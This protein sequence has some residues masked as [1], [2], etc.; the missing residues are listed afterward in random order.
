MGSLVRQSIVAIVLLF[1]FGVIFFVTKPGTL[2]IP[3]PQQNNQNSNSGVV[4]SQRSMQ[5]QT[6]PVPPSNYSAPSPTDCRSTPTKPP[7]RLGTMGDRI[8]GDTTSYLVSYAF[9]HA[10]GRENTVFRGEGAVQEARKL[11]RSTP[12]GEALIDVGA[13]VGYVSMYGAALGRPVIAVEPI[14]YLISKLCEGWRAN[15]ES[16]QV[17]VYHAAAGATDNSSVI[18]TRP[19]DAVGNFGESSLSRGAVFQKDIVTEKI[20]MLRLDSVVPSD[21][22]VGVVK[23]DVQGHEANVVAGMAAILSRDRGFPRHV[24]YETN[25]QIEKASGVRPGE[26]RRLLEGHGYRCR[27][28]CGSDVHCQKN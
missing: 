18:I 15:G 8:P 9:Y 3:A 4:K 16:S 7:M 28:C 1:T 17:T 21:L 19:S 13:N 12:D 23:I 20:P 25:A 22:P 6:A 26:A 10:K 14:S 5:Q 24:I 11:L 2:I 27:P